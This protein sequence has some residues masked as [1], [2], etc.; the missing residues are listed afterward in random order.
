MD[1][2]KFARQNL[3][4]LS[5][6]PHNWQV[7]LN[8]LLKFILNLSTYLVSTIT[9]LVQ[10]KHTFHLDYCSSLLTVLSALSPPTPLKALPPLK[11]TKFRPI[12]PLQ[13]LPVPSACNSFILVLNQFLYMAGSSCR[14]SA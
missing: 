12:R 7:L 11:Y 8:L 4:L 13:G 5:F 14:S 1:P 2:L 9:I 3:I 6:T 10:A